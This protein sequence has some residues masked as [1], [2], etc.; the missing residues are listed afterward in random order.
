MQNLK[1]RLLLLIVLGVFFE[2]FA[3]QYYYHRAIYA[4]ATE[5]QAKNYCNY[6]GSKRGN[7]FNIWGNRPL[8]EG[9]IYFMEVSG[10]LGYY[11][12][13]SAAQTSTNDADETVGPGAQI[14]LSNVC[15]PGPNYKYHRM[16]F[17]G[18]STI[19]V[20]RYCQNTSQDYDF[21]VNIFTNDRLPVGNIYPI[22]IGSQIKYYKVIT[23]SNN[24]NQDADE[25]ININA[26]GS[27]IDPCSLPSYKYHRLKFVGNSPQ[28]TGRYCYDNATNYDLKANLLLKDLLPIGKTYPITINNQTKYYKVITASG[29]QSQDADENI[30]G[31]AIG[32]SINPCDYPSYK[33]HR[34]KFVGNTTVIAANYCADT[35]QDWDFKVNILTRNTLTVGKTYPITVGGGTKYY[36]V[37]TV[38]NSQSQDADENINSS[39]V[40]TS[41][42]LCALPVYKNHK[43]KLLDDTTEFLGR[44]CN[45]ASTNW[46]VS[47]NIL[48][49]TPLTVGNTY[50]VTID[51]KTKYYKVISTSTNA[52][53]DTNTNINASAIG[54]AIDICSLATYKYHRLRLLGTSLNEL[55]KYCND[56]AQV[57][58]LKANILLE[59][60]LPVGTTYPITLNNVTKYYKVVTASDTP[61]QDADENMYGNAI[62]NAID[63]CSIRSYKY[64]RLRLLGNTPEETGRYCNDNT[65]V[66]NLKVNILLEN[67]LPVNVTYP[68]TINNIT[69][70]YKV[71]TA[72]DAQN[73]DADENL[74]E[75]AVGTP[76]N[77]CD[78]SSYK[79]HRLKYLG[80]TTGEAVKGCKPS[81]D[82][83]FKANIW[84]QEP[85]KVDKIYKINDAYYKVESASN[86][87][88]QDADETLDENTTI[89]GPVETIC[90]DIPRLDVDENFVYTIRPR[91]PLNSEEL[92]EVV[93]NPTSDNE[94][95]TI[96]SVDYYDD[97]GR[98]KQMI[99]I[100]AGG[101]KE[102]IVTP[103]VYDEFGRQSKQ[104]LSFSV[105]NSNPGVI[106]SEN[107]ELLNKQYHKNKYQEDFQANCSGC[108]N[109][110][111]ETVLENSPLSRSLKS[112]FPGTSWL[113]NRQND[114]DRTMKYEYTSNSVSE[115]STV[116]DDVR[117]YRVTFAFNNT[118]I[119]QLES[120]EYYKPNEIY[121]RIVKDE[122]W[123]PNQTNEKDYTTEEF[124]NKKGQVV[125]KRTYSNNIPHETYYVYDDY[126]NLTYVIPPKVD[127]SDGISDNELNELCYQYR[128]DVRNR[129][130]EK[131][132]PGKGWEYIVYNKLD[133]PILTQDS[134]L[135]SKQQWLLTKYDV[136]GRVAYTGFV[137]DGSIR[138]VVQNRANAST[139]PI[140]E[141]KIDAVNTLG[142]AEIYYT[143]NSY[144][145]RGILRVYTV[146]YYDDYNFD[147]NVSAPESVYD[148]S[149][150]TNVTGLLTGSKVRVLGGDDWTTTVNYYDQKG[151][152][153][154]VHST[155][156]YLN[157]TDIVKTKLDFTGNALKVRSKHQKGS[158]SEIVTVDTFTYDHMNRLLSQNQC[159]GDDSLVD[160]CGD[161]SIA[162]KVEFN[163]EITSTQNIEASNILLSPGFTFLGAT[164]KTFS[165]VAKNGILTNENVEQIVNNSYD[166]IGQ[167]TTKTVGGGLQDVNYKYNVRGW[168]KEINDVDNLGD[169]L[170]AFK[171]NY[172]QTEINSAKPLFNGN[173]SET[174]WKTANDNQL[175]N[176]KYS[177]DALNRI[178][179]AKS[180]EG[181]FD[182]RQVD[183]DKNGNIKSL[184]RIGYMELDEPYRERDYDWMD[185]LNYEYDTGNKLLKVTDTAGKKSGFKDGSNT[186]DDYE[187]DANG[188]MTID[189]N[190]GIE[191]ISYN[192]LNLPTV[193]K[194][195]GSFISYVYDA[196][197]NKLSKQLDINRG[198]TFYAGKYVYE[199]KPRVGTFLTFINHSQGYIIPKNEIDFSEGFEYVY[200]YKDHLG[201]IRL[202]Y[203]D[204]NEDGN[205]T[206]NEILEEKNYYPFGL[207]H[208]GYNAA[209][210]GISHNYGFNGKEEHNE[211]GLEWLDLGARNYDP[212]IARFMVIDPMAD[213]MKNQTPYVLADNNPV[214]LVDIY[215]FGGGKKPK[216]G[217]TWIGRF[218]R[219]IGG[220]FVNK[221]KRITSG[222][223]IKGRSS[224]NFSR[225]TGMPVRKKTPQKPSD[226]KPDPIKKEESKSISNSELNALFGGAKVPTPDP[227]ILPTLPLPEL[228]EAKRKDPIIEVG[229]TPVNIPVSRI[230]ILGQPGRG[231]FRVGNDPTTQ[232][233]L[234]TV[235]NTLIADPNV[236]LMISR[237]SFFKGRQFDHPDLAKSMPGINI[238]RSEAIKSFLIARGI[239][240]NRIGV[241]QGNINFE[242][243]KGNTITNFSFTK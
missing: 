22:T 48:I 33:Y 181:N 12:I 212:T 214:K 147:H 129:I 163:K 213:F 144:P 155:N 4:G 193:V 70:Y 184:I 21:K 31:T 239:S 197:G 165:G 222:D 81:S 204:T 25:N 112:G 11:F 24:Q 53:S 116:G 120:G 190:K 180:N 73:Q 85:L 215:G 128:Y 71:I 13:K 55:P 221:S 191:G 233:F 68:I 171:I 127:V 92:E 192:H 160:N 159:I 93:Q 119:P 69:K 10:D 26:V 18:T 153:I 51:N 174:H 201:N 195:N 223:R 41:I 226:S 125:L 135:K 228:M 145:F 47:V 207:Q 78:F 162:S 219:S 65:Q 179:T 175:R 42:D 27:V 146:N 39:A 75:N 208:K 151:R 133:L 64:H 107:V 240:P 224:E 8:T 34:M 227:M 59:N 131:K 176:Y 113:V 156:E 182:V 97:L 218:L 167:L 237:D 143:N 157:T 140:Y 58:D 236:T 29:N 95:K 183:Y 217:T 187:Y 142:K 19:D 234:N 37:I 132:I 38:S 40:G 235:L 230:D 66:W 106:I 108:E 205:V 229:E 2:S 15:N 98:K 177:Y 134:N 91:V 115:A 44:F 138:K 43:L 141:T 209:V 1:T 152:S 203:K 88:Q 61:S 6:N 178:T 104:Y 63:I 102:D 7:K 67:K 56:N 126:D 186:D 196:M 220:L 211:L 198:K 82:W 72:S 154:Y 150:T 210:N 188:N 243:R 114:N 99:A 185:W 36:K 200:Q 49:A 46:D 170:F 136:F 202:S 87:A 122:N 173:I 189:K 84:L 166:E 199:E 242:A 100:N 149:I 86:T 111:T 118:E 57:W 232:Q 225:S 96:R 28:E 50:P 45:D 172:D 52:N 20:A 94:N 161:V 130:I 109:P 123:S 101:Q 117:L 83:D 137:S 89:V 194:A 32:A 103:I 30:N 168:L 164:N 16:K 17:V 23:T 241:R 238:D 60:I 5:A 14:E 139:G 110:Y 35:S 79:Y 158:Q 105:N 80:K 3:Q 77:P 90:N 9:E 216:P 148:Q 124:T 76:I 169:D 74:E 121:K 206:Q 54:N 231:N 62:G